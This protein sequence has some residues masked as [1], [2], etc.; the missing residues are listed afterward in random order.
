MTSVLRVRTRAESIHD[1]AP[2]P[3]FISW[4]LQRFDTER[5]VLT[6]SF[7]MEGCALID[8][9][10]ATGIPLT[11]V[12]LDTMFFFAETY[13]LRDRMIERYPHLTFVNRGTTLTP[14]EQ[15]ANYGPA[16]WTS[17]RDKCCELRKVEPMRAALADADVWVT[18][19]TRSQ[20]QFRSAVPLVGWDWQFQV[21]KVCPLARWDRARVWDYVRAHDVPF[22]PLHAHGYP[23][24]GCTHC[25]APVAGVPITSYSR[26]GR[27]SGAE[28]TECGLHIGQQ[29]RR[30]GRSQ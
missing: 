3:A 6:T 22:N 9:Y 7:G 19:I 15:E 12:Y 1:D 29:D 14:E 20:G 25:T 27:W 17:D 8:M 4:T 30:E 18:A 11:V 28:K 23:S 26:H 2:T 10:A 21:I 16:L 5:L 13:A 24:I